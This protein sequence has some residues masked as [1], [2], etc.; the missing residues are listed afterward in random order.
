ML[1]KFLVFGQALI[2]VFSRDCDVS[3]C[4]TGFVFRCHCLKYIGTVLDSPDCF[5][6]TT[7][8]LSRSQH[9][10]LAKNRL[11]LDRASQNGRSR[12]K[13]QL[14]V[15]FEGF[16]NLSNILRFFS[17]LTRDSIPFDHFDFLEVKPAFGHHESRKARDTKPVFRYVD[18]P[19]RRIVFRLRHNDIAVNRV[20][21]QSRAFVSAC[22]REVKDN[23]R[24]N[25]ELFRLRNDVVRKI[26]FQAATTQFFPAS[27]SRQRV[28]NDDIEAVFLDSVEDILDAGHVSDR[29]LSNSQALA[30]KSQLLNRLLSGNIRSFFARQLELF[31]HL[32]QERSLAG[33][34]TSSKRKGHS[35]QETLT[36]EE[37]IEVFLASLETTIVDFRD[38]HVASARELVVSFDY[39]HCYKYIGTVL[40]RQLYYA[41]NFKN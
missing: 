21:K 20:R 15:L 37:S 14:S 7:V 36:A 29:H 16:S 41:L 23:T 34:R 4:E 38:L 28:E 25:F 22:L 5:L 10:Q 33:T 2:I 18:L 13:G 11:S 31:E 6:T 27:Q 35:R 24:H 19:D 3:C 40:D 39:F 32:N 17:L 12:L 9:R 26:L 30:G 8:F 1:K